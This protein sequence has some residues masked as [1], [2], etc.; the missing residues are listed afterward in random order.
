MKT[1]IF[2]GKHSSLNLKLIF[3]I[4]YLLYLLFKFDRWHLSEPTSRSYLSLCTSLANSLENKQAVLDI[5]CGLGEIL[6]TISYK[7]KLGID[8]DSNVISAAKLRS[9]LSLHRPQFIEKDV[10]SSNLEGSFDCILLLNWI[11]NIPPQQIIGLVKKLIHNNLAIGGCII[12]EGVFADGY[13]YH[14]HWP[15]YQK[16]MKSTS[17]YEYSV[18]SFRSLYRV[19]RLC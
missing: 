1:K 5:G 8:I 2:S 18:N 19:G 7:K 14:H 16:S 11:H 10:F 12:T 4:K 17:I 3:S 13:K 9:Y 6:D 15:T